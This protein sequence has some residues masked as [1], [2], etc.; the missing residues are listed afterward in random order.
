MVLHWCSRGMKKAA[1]QEGPTS[2]PLAQTAVS[3]DGSMTCLWKGL[4]AR[5]ISWEVPSP[6][7]TTAPIPPCLEP[8]SH[9]SLERLAQRWEQCLQLWEGWTLRCWRAPSPCTLLCRNCWLV[10]CSP[11]PMEQTHWQGSPI[12]FSVSLETNLCLVHSWHSIN[13]CYRERRGER[14]FLFHLSLLLVA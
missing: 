3:M 7:N 5:G 2:V 9:W 14:S 8:L 6:N 12:V 10:L 1:A 11:P 4:I 13:V